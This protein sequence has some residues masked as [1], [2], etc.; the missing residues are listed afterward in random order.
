[1]G[2]TITAPQAS[3]IQFSPTAKEHPIWG[4]VDFKVPVYAEDDLAFQ[5]MITADTEAEADDL[6]AIQETQL[7][8]LGLVGN[9]AYSEVL[10]EFAESPSRFRLNETDVLY[11][12][13]HGLPGFQGVCETG[14]CFRIRAEVAGEF[15]YSNKLERLP[16]DEFTTVVEYASDDNAYGFNYCASGGLD[17]IEPPSQVGGSGAVCEPT[18][19]R[20]TNQEQ[21]SIPYTAQM[22]DYYGTIPTV[23]VWIYDETGELVNAGIPIKFDSYPPEVISIDLGGTASGIIIIK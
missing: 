12:W 10:I 4:T 11:N 8:K 3:F 5:F 21:I 22:Q 13:E 16:S 20:F 2:V 19:I 18:R 23:Q 14:S 1:M 6:M 7:V 15:F 9:G 17:E